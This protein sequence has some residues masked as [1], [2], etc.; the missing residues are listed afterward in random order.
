MTLN[1]KAEGSKALGITKHK[2]CLKAASRIELCNY[3]LH[4]VMSLLDLLM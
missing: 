2:F 3:Q 1:V 4:M